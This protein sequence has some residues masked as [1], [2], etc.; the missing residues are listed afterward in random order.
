MTKLAGMD[1]PGMVTREANGIPHVF[2]LNMHDAIFLNGWLHAQDRLF[3]MDTTRRIASGTLG[4][5]LGSAALSNDV[6]LR[7][8]GVRRAAEASLAVYSA[9]ARAALDAYTAGINAYLQAHPGQLPPEYSLLGIQSI[10][11][12][13]PVDSVAIGKAL[14]LQL[15]FDL[16]LDATV[17]LISDQ[18]AGKIV[19]FNGT[20]LFTDTW[21]LA[22]FTKAAT[23]PD[24]TGAGAAEPIRINGQTSI[25]TSWIKPETAGLL[26]AYREQIRNNATLMAAVDPERHAGSNEWAIAP[27]NS[28]TGNALIA[29]D[30][31]LAL[32]E[33][34]T[35]YPISLRV[36]G[37]LNVAGMG[38]PGAPFVI[39]GQNER[40][41]WGSTVHPMDVT[42]LYQEQL[43]P[44]PTSP[45]GFAS[46]YL[47]KKENVIPIPET[48]RI[49]TPGSGLSTVPAAAGLPPVTLMVP[50]HGPI[51]QL[52]RASG[53]AV[54]V[55]YAG[56][57]P[58]HEL[59]AFMLINQAKNIDDF[60]AAL[61]HFD[62]GS[63]NFVY[64]D[65]DGNIAYF[66]SAEMP[67]REDLQANK[68]NGVPPY[69]VR[70]GQGGNEWI[71]PVVHPQPQ[72]ALPFE[73][74]PYSE[75]PQVVN[76]SN[77]WFVNANNDPIGQSLDND[78][79]NMQRPGGGIYY[80]NPS[81]DGFRAGRITQLV[82]Q[83]LA[84]SG[85]ISVADMQS[86]QADTVLVD[87]EVF[88]PY[89]L[90]AMTNARKPGA[91]ATLA[92]LGSS[93]VVAAA[94]AQLGTW[95]FSTPTG[96]DTG[97]DAVETNG[98]LQPPSAT[99][100]SNSVGATIYAA[101]R[102]KFLANTIDVVLKTITLPL[103]PSQQTLSALRFQLENFSTTGGR[104][105][106]G[107]SFFNVP[108]VD[109]A[110]TRRD[111]LILKSVADG[112]TMLASDAF[113]PAFNKSTNLSDYR[114]GKIHRVVFAHLMGNLYSPGA[115]FGQPPLPSL[116]NLPGVATDGGMSTVDVASHNP[117]ANTVN[118]FMF[119]NGPNRRYVGEMNRVPI[120][121]S[122]L[123]GGV[124]GDPRSPFFTN[125]LM[126]WLT[127]DTFPVVP[128]SF[129]R[130]PWLP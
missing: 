56:F 34:P 111:I 35:F 64:G 129:P 62:V 60:K 45:S 68:V 103:P 53:V 14:A 128:D 116:A 67:I 77:G 4:E 58:T 121:Q 76:P 23:I 98:V 93:P 87:A 25:D 117:R 114:W 1:Q 10:P 61:Q 95:D 94:V 24:A 37:K 102:S 84:N 69:F 106:S 125:L 88:V 80:L 110:A 28:A 15:S 40:I 105:S 11:A 41:A 43:V 83:K 122:S 78:P 127:N 86:I 16:D 2:A 3:Q 46:I 59:E 82:R 12:W 79:L 7:T 126:Q 112:M 72:Q 99:E 29:N 65:V 27:R 36:P 48:Y 52:D 44:E 55:Q 85:K 6:Q 33:P 104:G 109:D 101:W 108:G 22:P 21:R 100:I 31:H 124:S 130:I 90:A 71:T 9:D 8:F 38:F 5:V 75:M 51:L 81:Y 42:D 96:I 74:L 20:K 97:Y 119:T 26:R 92:A 47:G 107:L 113:A 63:Q 115:P 49:W 54:S 57:Y 123:P 13:T 66:T 17:A 30:P 39:Q 18:T 19:G 89:I 73:I 91:D 120:G 32:T 118:G 50:R 70:N